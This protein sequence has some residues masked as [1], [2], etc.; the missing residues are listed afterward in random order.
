MH[1]VRSSKRAL[2]KATAEVCSVLRH[3]SNIAN[4]VYPRDKD[5]YN[6]GT[7][8]KGVV[9]HVGQ[10]ADGYSTV[11]KFPCFEHYASYNVNK[12]VFIISIFSASGGHKFRKHVRFE[13]L[14]L[15]PV[16]CV[17]AMLT[18]LVTNNVFGLFVVILATL[19]IGVANPCT[20]LYTDKCNGV[21]LTNGEGDC[22]SL[23]GGDRTYINCFNKCIIP[24]HAFEALPCKSNVD[25]VYLDYYNISEIQPEAFKD[26][27]KLSVLYLSNNEIQ[28]LHQSTFQQFRKLMKL[29]VSFNRLRYIHPEA[30]VHMKSFYD[31]NVSHNVLVLN[32]TI[33]Y[34]D[35]INI[36]DAAFCNPTKDASWYV[37]KYPVFNGLPNLT[38]LVLEGNG[39]QCVMWDTFSN[40]QRLNSLDLRNNMLKFLPHQ[41][42]LC[43]HVIE[44]D[45]SNNP[46][47]CNCYMKMYAASCPNT[48]VK[49]GEV[50]CG[51][52]TG[53]EHLSC[54][55]VSFTD[56][57]VIGICDFDIGSTYAVT[58]TLLTSEGTS[59]DNTISTE[60]SATSETVMSSLYSDQQ[61]PTS[62]LKASNK[63]A[64]LV[65]FSSTSTTE[66][67]SDFSENPVAAITK[68]SL[69]NSFMLIVFGAVFVLVV[70]IVAVSV[71]VILRVCRRQDYEGSVPATHYFDFLFGKNNSET[72]NKVNENYRRSGYI[73]LGSLQ[74]LMA[75]KQD[76]H[77]LCRD[78][79]TLPGVSVQGQ[80]ETGSC[81]FSVILEKNIATGCKHG[82]LE[83]HVYEEVV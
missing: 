43:S 1:Y 30:F 57:P 11:S 35:Y 62:A 39:I 3:I 20:V 34:S 4:C 19:L 59:Q 80:S 16:D 45:L 51:T 33:L 17:V 37:L 28:E 55:D 36:L 27:P 23:V 2:S 15:V 9:I 76:L 32:G 5:T 71:V 26:L 14:S 60:F 41:N 44:L 50:S 83:E 54:D 12:V 65:E 8:T 70:I 48:S 75:T 56:P 40:N 79:T 47:E 66:I 67:P 78:V 63:S 7:Y 61:S 81:S 53:L 46:I 77:Y 69:T 21:S 31:L 22:E 10:F 58:S 18:M 68:A 24:D 82:D 42:T 29:D 52:P 74:E 64:N 38:K 13:V 6:L 49:L 73:S 72:Y 25:A